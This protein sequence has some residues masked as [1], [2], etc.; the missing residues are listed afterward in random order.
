MQGAAD[1]GETEQSF[2]LRAVLFAGTVRAESRAGST[3]R[4]ARGDGRARPVHIH[5]PRERRRH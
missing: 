3:G 2:R 5:R 4:A 1:A